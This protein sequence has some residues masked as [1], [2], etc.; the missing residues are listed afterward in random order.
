MGGSGFKEFEAY[1][2]KISLC[3]YV[4]KNLS[5]AH[6]R[7]LSNYFVCILPDEQQ[8]A[9]LGQ[10]PETVVDDELQFV[11]LIA[12]LVEHWS[13]GVVVG[14][15][16][17]VLVANLVG[18]LTGLDKLLDQRLYGGSS[19]GNLLDELDVTGIQTGGFLIVEYG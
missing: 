1:V 19:L 15:G 17:L 8:F 13:N 9:I 4:E 7:A 10:W 3:L 11:N 5:V 18:Y 16:F 6:E 12:N 14:N 2:F